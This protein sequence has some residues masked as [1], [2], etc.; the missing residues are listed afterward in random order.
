MENNLEKALGRERLKELAESGEFV[1]HGS[2]DKVGEFE[3]RQAFTGF[4]EKRRPDGHPAVFA[5]DEI[6]IPIFMAIFHKENMPQGFRSSFSMTKEG[7]TLKA[8]Q[9]SLDQAKKGKG[10]VYVFKKSDFE[11]R[12]GNEWVSTK[13]VI[14]VETVM[15]SYEDMSKDIEVLDE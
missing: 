2:A 11:K 15:V 6:E 10:Y 14:P 8:T 13:T 1:F 3:P 5:S 12:N 4:K 9:K 7:I